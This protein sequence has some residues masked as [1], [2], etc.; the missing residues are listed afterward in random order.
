MNDTAPDAARGSRRAINLPAR[1]YAG[2]DGLPLAY[3]ETGDGRPLLLI[4]GFFSTAGENWIRYGHAATLA[5]RGF[6]VIMPDLRAHGDSSK[7]HDPAA[8]PPDVLTDD[9]FAL[10]DHLGLAEYDLAGYSLGGRVVIRMLARGA[11]PSRAVVA[12]TGVE[13]ITHSVGR[14]DFF[15]RV[16]TNLGTFQRGSAE[17]MAEA[18]LNTVGGD[19]K[20]LLRVLDTFVDTPAET[21]AAIPTRTLVLMGVADTDH[22]DGRALAAALPAGEYGQVPGNHMSAVVKPDLGEAIAAFLT[23]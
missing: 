7:P 12:G 3:R 15:H 17:W 23:G 10:A 11:R 21:L 18:F 22:G 8:Y 2:R 4:H 16:L 20:A 9:A 5:A 14:G 6:R 19:P 1:Q 13:P